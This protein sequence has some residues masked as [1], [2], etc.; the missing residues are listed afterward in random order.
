MHQALQALIAPY[1]C[2]SIIGM[3]KNAGKTCVLNEL[4]RQLSGSGLTLGLTSIGRDGEGQDLVTGTKKPGIY[5]PSGTLLATASEL[6]LRSCNVTREILATSGFSTPMGEVVLFRARSDGAVQLAG[7]SITTQLSK[8]REDFFRFGADKVLIDG[9]LSRKSLCSRSVTD[10]TI[11]CTG[12]SYHRNLQTVVEDTAYQCQLLMLP[13]AQEPQLRRAAAELET[14]RSPVILTRSGVWAVPSGMALPDA[15]RQPEAAEAS[16]VLFGGALSD[17]TV[18]PLLL[19]AALP[20]LTLVVRDSSKLLLSREVY[21]K[22]LRKGLA[23]QVLEQVNLVA[24]TINPF[25]AYGFSFRKEELAQQMQAHVNIPVID[26]MEE[27]TAW[28]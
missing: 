6:L 14:S 10:A 13:E 22:L 11:L 26:V 17:F 28:N 19:S 18:K 25:S 23:L 4:I 15:L 12:A 21:Q 16:A 20:P 5:V 1:R 8:L 2:V 9:A 3:C 27:H 7:P 24:L